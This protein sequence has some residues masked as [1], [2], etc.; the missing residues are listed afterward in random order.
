MT[1]DENL[2]NDEIHLKGRAIELG[3]YFPIRERFWL[4]RLHGC[5]KSDAIFVCGNAHIR[6][7]TTLL[8]AEG[9]KYSIVERGIGV[10]PEE[11]E[12]WSRIEKY[13]EAHPQLRNG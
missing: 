1:D 7:L 5:R 10:T 6:T 13:L 9:I 4:E 12:D 2:S 11:D 8:D 3:H